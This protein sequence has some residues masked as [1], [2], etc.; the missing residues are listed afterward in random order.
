MNGLMVLQLKAKPVLLIYKYTKGNYRNKRLTM[1]LY[2]NVWKPLL[3]SAFLFFT[4]C[5][6]SDYPSNITPVQPIENFK[7]GHLIVKAENTQ[8]GF[9][10]RNAS[11]E[12]LEHTLK[13]KLTNLLSNQNGNHF[14]HL[15]VVVSG[16][17]LAK[18]GIPVILSPKSVL[19]IDVS[20]FDDETEQKVFSK[21]KRF[22]IFESLSSNTIIGSG[23]TLTAEEQLDNLTTI[24][25][26]KI[27]QWLISNKNIFE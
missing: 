17:V 21:P 19:I 7:L 12:I 23:L 13:T 16:Y 4:S 27:S 5:S 10:S 25:T 22:S 11:E 18:P 15:S 2:I 26:H 6:I 1:K 20:I 8:R 9:F 14:F 3:I 24:A